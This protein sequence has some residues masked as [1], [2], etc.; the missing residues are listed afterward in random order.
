MSISKATKKPVYV[1]VR[2]SMGT[3]I[4]EVKQDAIEGQMRCEVKN[5]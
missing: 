3:K 1:T 4:R 5:K 2:K